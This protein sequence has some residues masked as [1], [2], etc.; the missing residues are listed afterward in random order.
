MLFCK[1][2]FSIDGRGWCC[3]PQLSK[4]RNTNG[5]AKVHS[6]Q[7]IMSGSSY[8]DHAEFSMTRTSWNE[9]LHVPTIE[10]K[11]DF[12]RPIRSL[13]R[14][15]FSCAIPH[16]LIDTFTR[17]AGS[18]TLDAFTTD[19]LCLVSLAVVVVRVPVAWR[20]WS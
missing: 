4:A 12:A 18:T 19:H 10:R 6:K 15:V 7:P 1:R 5:V 13:G 16:P 11:D 20:R 8:I 9:V 14:S 17:N 2:R 3:S